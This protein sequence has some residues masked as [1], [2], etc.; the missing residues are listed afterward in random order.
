MD[1]PPIGGYYGL[2]D[3]LEFRKGLVKDTEVA[4]GL[5]YYYCYYYLLLLVWSQQLPVWNSEDYFTKIIGQGIKQ[6]SLR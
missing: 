1:V 3:S 5:C 4:Q 2:C 6:N